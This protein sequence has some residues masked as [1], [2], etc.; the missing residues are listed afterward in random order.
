MGDWLTQ[1]AW[2]GQVE[3]IS[4]SLWDQR[5]WGVE[6]SKGLRENSFKVEKYLGCRMNRRFRD[7]SSELYESCKGRLK[8]PHIIHA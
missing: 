6:Y 5:M 7:G 2:Q 3:Y 4:G 1:T 8:L